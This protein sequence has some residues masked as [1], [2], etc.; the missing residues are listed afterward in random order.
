MP[1][2]IY[3]LSSKAAA[4]WEL[5]PPKAVPYP[6]VHLTGTGAKKKGACLPRCENVA[7]GLFQHPMLLPARGQDGLYILRLLINRLVPREAGLLSE[8]CHRLNQ[9]IDLGVKQC[10]SVPG[11]NRLDSIV[12]AEIPVLHRDLIG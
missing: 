12:R 4:S 6:A 11:L 7:G 9:L 2:H 1:P 3:S 10:L 8:P 5:A